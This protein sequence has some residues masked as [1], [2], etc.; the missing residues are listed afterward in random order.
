MKLAT[1]SD[2]ARRWG[3]SRQRVNQLMQKEGFPEPE[4]TLGSGQQLFD[5]E[6]ADTWRK[7][8]RDA[9]QTSATS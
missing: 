8:R 2:L 9:W 4:Q 1:Q 6:K 5:L 7:E 3:I